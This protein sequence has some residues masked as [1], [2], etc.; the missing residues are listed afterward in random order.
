MNERLNPVRH[1][2]DPSSHR[3]VS[4]VNIHENIK[5]VRFQPTRNIPSP[6]SAS[7]SS[8]STCS[9]IPPDDCESNAS[10][11]SSAQPRAERPA[12][13]VNDN[14]NPEMQPPK[15]FFFLMKI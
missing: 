7:D 10:D 1:L 4:S 2:H 6:P 11:I 12:N 14:V 13:N 5:R 9:P 8:P 3:R 15:P